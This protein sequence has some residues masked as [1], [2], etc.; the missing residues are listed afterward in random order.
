VAQQ[1]GL[2]AVDEGGS[3]SSGYTPL[4][5]SR[6]LELDSSWNAPTGAFDRVVIAS[7]RVFESS[8]N[9]TR[10][11]HNYLRVIA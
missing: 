8:E 6:L 9:V 10:L 4:E 3:A 1:F 11:M 7:V 5:L 2:G